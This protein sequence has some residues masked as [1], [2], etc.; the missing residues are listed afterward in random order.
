MMRYYSCNIHIHN[1]QRG[2]KGDL[3]DMSLYT[4]ML[5]VYII[6]EIYKIHRQGPNGQRG[7]K[8]DPGP[9]GP[10]GPPGNNAYVWQLAT[11]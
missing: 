6:Y 4:Q 11:N 5:C 10:N 2:S 8:G 7:S 1:G 3:L 9:N